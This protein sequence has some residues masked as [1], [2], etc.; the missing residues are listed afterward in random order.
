MPRFPKSEN[1]KNPM[2]VL[3][4]KLQMS[5]AEFSAKMG[6]PIDTIRSIENGRISLKPGSVYGKIGWDSKT[7]RFAK[8]TVEFFGPVLSK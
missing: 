6:I 7:W 4:N 8:V 3:R 5:Q 2:R 1:V